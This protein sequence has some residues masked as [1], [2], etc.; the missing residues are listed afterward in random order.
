MYC[1]V[2]ASLY[3]GTLRGRPNEILVFINLLAHADCSGTVDKHFKAIADETG[4]GVEE[5]KAAVQVL[6]SPDPES[7][8][9]EQGG[10]R[11]IRLDEHRVWGWQIVNYVKYRAIRNTEDRREQNRL[12]QAR[13][14][15]QSKPPSARVSQPQP[16]SAELSPGHVQSAHA[17]AE[18]EAEAVPN[19]PIVP[20]PKKD[21][22]PK[23]KRPDGLGLEEMGL[24]MRLAGL[25][26][27]RESSTWKD[28]EVRAFRKYALTTT[29]EEIDLLVWYYSQ[30]DAEYKRHDLSTLLNNFTSVI[31]RARARRAR[32][33]V[34]LN[35]A[36]SARQRRRGPSSLRA[37]RRC[38]GT[39]SWRM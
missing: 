13:F 23:P 9:P 30:P 8:S 19:P 29:P 33:P 37:C 15:Q 38:F 35:G 17:E 24:A 2:L 18:A 26:N 39:G 7:R 11:L 28:S 5:V 6:E 16:P 27:R 14:R 20:P 25:F 3:Q 22:A 31:D 1:K 36:G 21:G 4:L 12:A 10:A 32:P 34:A